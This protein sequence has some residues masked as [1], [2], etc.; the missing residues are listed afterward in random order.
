MSWL[1]R[2]G[3]GSVAT[4]IAP[5]TQAHVERLAA[6][7][8][9][10]FARPWGADDFAGY[11][12]ENAVRIDGLFVGRER[13][14]SGFVVSRSVLDEAEILSVALARAVRGRGHSFKLLA[15]HLQSLAHAG[16]ARVHLEVEDGNQPALA[17]Y[18]RLGFVQSG[19]RP[20]YYTRPDG[21][22]AGALSMTRI[23]ASAATAAPAAPR[24]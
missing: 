15:T 1:A 2:L 5:V 21:S 8:A 13:Q 14:P 4:R 10:A 18:R 19:T 11:L 16:V 9:G 12:T 6:I 20:N 3:V 23:L 24:R 7:H 22:R 17:L